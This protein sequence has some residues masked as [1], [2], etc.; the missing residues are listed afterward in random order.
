MNYINQDINSSDSEITSERDTSS[1]AE[2][3]TL[4]KLV[5][6]KQKHLDKNW[7]RK[8]KSIKKNIG[9]KRRIVPAAQNKHVEK[10]HISGPWKLYENNSNPMQ[11]LQKLQTLSGSVKKQK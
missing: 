9:K 2:S 11:S 7:K 5:K 3:I 4:I 6:P 8:G 10:G 1:E